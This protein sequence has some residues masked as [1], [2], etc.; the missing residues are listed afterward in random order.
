MVNYYKPIKGI[1][2]NAH[3]VPCPYYIPDDFVLI[4]VATPPGLTAFRTGDTITV[5][6]S[7]KYVIILSG[8]TQSQEGLN[9]IAGDT[10]MGMLFC[11]RV[12]N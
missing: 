8:Y 10:T 2:I 12:P 9:A 1:P 3:L 4:Q 11:G 7:E 6:G 5:S